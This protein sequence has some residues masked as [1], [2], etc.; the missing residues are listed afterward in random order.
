MKKIGLVGLLMIGSFSFGFSAFAETDSQEMEGSFSST[1]VTTPRSE[2]SVKEAETT[3]PSIEESGPAI[4][5][6]S[7]ATVP[8]TEA[9]TDTTA[10]SEENIVT[11][12]KHTASPA[13]SYTKGATPK[14]ED[15]KAVLEQVL[16]LRF[17]TLA[18]QEGSDQTTATLD[19]HTTKLLATDTNGTSYVITCTY[20]V[21]S[22]SPTLNAPIIN[23][24]AQTNMLT[25][26][27]FPYASVYFYEVGLETKEPLQVVHADANGNFSIS[28]SNFEAGRLMSVIV[29]TVGGVEFSEPVLF[30]IPLATGASSE[31]SS[32]D[33]AETAATTTT[34][35]ETT[36]KKKSFP[37]TGESDQNSLIYSGFLSLISACSLILLRKKHNHSS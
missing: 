13:A 11:E 34:E 6:S 23:Y 3:T 12:L 26:I 16:K 28:G 33:S 37:A 17:H 20:I 1:E 27:T 7:E 5:E 2:E 21:K 18:F 35:Q 24:D 22:D 14:A 25:G 19:L 15:F 8:S 29:Y 9:T 10:S 31:S 4:I 32:S 30:K 36:T